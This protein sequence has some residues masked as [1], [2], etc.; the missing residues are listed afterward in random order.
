MSI[1]P[2]IRFEVF[3]RDGFTCAYCG[4]HPPEATL[5]ADHIIPVCEG[6]DDDYEN[7][8]TACWECNRGKGAKM[9]EAAPRDMPDLEERTALLV[10][11]ER[12]LRAYQEAR[13]EATT[14]REAIFNDVR[15]HWLNIWGEESVPHYYMPWDSALRRY[16]EL[17]GAEDVKASM[18]TARRKF[19]YLNTTPVR[20]FIGILK[21]KAGERGNDV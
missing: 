1:R 15:D 18:D 20:Y 3:K 12:Q 13:D 10:E 8:I 2:S 11:R 16:I 14:R 7:L 5:E 19:S 4:K 17:L 6:G 21:H 9:L